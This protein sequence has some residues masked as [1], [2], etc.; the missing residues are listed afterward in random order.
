MLPDD[1]YR[2]NHDIIS[3][4]VEEILN[5]LSSNEP[6]VSNPE[7]NEKITSIA[8]RIREATTDSFIGE[9]TA[10]IKTWADACYSASKHQTYIGGAKELSSWIQGACDQIRI[11]ASF[12]K[13]IGKAISK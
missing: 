2:L 4:S 6:G 3:K 7:A 11:R 12:A 13:S 5:I 1:E 8:E 10:E 9:K